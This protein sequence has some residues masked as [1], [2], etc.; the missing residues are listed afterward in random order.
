MSDAQATGV[1]IPAFAG[2]TGGTRHL[3]H[4]HLERIVARNVTRYNA[5][6]RFRHSGLRRFWERGDASRLNQAHAPRIIRLLDMLDDA[7]TP[8]DMEQPGL[9]LHQLTGNRRGT[10][11]IRVSGNWRITFRFEDGEAVDVDLEDYH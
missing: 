9:W 11:S 7:R 10:W 6:M 2:M 3:S 5:G 4:A 1:W 8:E